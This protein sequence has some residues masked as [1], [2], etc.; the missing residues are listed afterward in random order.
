MEYVYIFFKDS[1]KT[2]HDEIKLSD[3]ASV[4][5]NEQNLKK[6]LRSLTIYTFGKEQKKVIITALK[7]FE[8]ILTQYPQLRLIPLGSTDIILEKN[9]HRQKR[10]TSILKAALICI[11]TFFGAAFT[12]IAFNNDVQVHEAFSQIYFFISGEESD[13]FTA[14]ECSY[15]LGLGIGIIVFYNHFGKKKLSPDPTPLEIEM[16]LYETDIKNT[17]INGVK[18][19][20]EHIDV[21]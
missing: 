12:I 11:I 13:G 7:V 19:N 10:P 18:R 21:S 1:A 8:T 17:L 3:I 16:R 15:A 14:L 2:D 5:C 4:C 20:N 6:Q 9:I